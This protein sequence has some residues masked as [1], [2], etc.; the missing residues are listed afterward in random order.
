MTTR[1]DTTRKDNCFTRID[2]NAVILVVAI[3]A[4]D[5]DTCRVA[6]IEAIGVGTKIISGTVVDSNVGQG[7]ISRVVDA[8]NLNW[9]VLDVEAGDTRGDQVVGIEEFGLGDTTVAALTVP[10]TR[11]ISIEVGAGGSS[12]GDIGTGDRDE[13][14]GPL[15]V[16]EGSFTLEDDLDRGEL[17]FTLL[18]H[19]KGRFLRGC[20]PS[21]R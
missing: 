4:S 7:E 12:H 5:G 10:P 15:L 13:R 3:S 16:T 20:P 17:C 11:T 19:E 6:N 2:G 1:A 18:E 8:E 9:R 14:T 21:S